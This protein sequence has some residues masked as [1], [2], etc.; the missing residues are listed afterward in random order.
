MSKTRASATMPEQDQSRVVPA[1]PPAAK[2]PPSLLRMMQEKL[3][4]VAVFVAGLLAGW[5]VVGGVLAPLPGLR[6]EPQNLTPKHKSLYLRLAADSYYW[7][8]DAQLIQDA[9]A[10]WEPSDLAGALAQAEAGT[11]DQGSRRRLAALRDLLD[12][13]AGPTTLLDFVR[14]QG[15][16]YVTLSLAALMFILAGGVSVIPRIQEA[17]AAENGKRA[18][19]GGAPSSAGASVFVLNEGESLEGL[20]TSLSDTSRQDQAVAEKVPAEAVPLLQQAETDV[21]PAQPAAEQ[22]PAKPEETAAETASASDG[23][24]NAAQAGEPTRRSD[25]GAQPPPEEAVATGPQT[26]GATAPAVPEAQESEPAKRLAR[27]PD[28]DA[29]AGADAQVDVATAQQDVLTEIFSD[30]DQVEEL[31][32]LLV[33]QVF[34]QVFTIEDLFD[35]MLRAISETV[36]DI[37]TDELVRKCHLVNMQLQARHCLPELVEVEEEVEVE[38]GV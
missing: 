34:S 5:L 21:T 1:R 15:P 7:A 16:I 8:S 29:E 32:K 27:G 30:K 35:P 37:R 17:V 22:K 13:P 26:N 3:P 14:R 18:A 11:T 12:I 19:A 31:Q 38:V 6:A 4:W 10:G 20:V 33:S 24:P 28:G 36:D 23:V 25:S 2:G 9:L